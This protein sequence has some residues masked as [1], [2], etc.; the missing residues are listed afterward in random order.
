M[1]GY[2]KQEGGLLGGKKRYFKLDGCSLHYFKDKVRARRSSARSSSARRRAVARARGDSSSFFVLFSRRAAPARRVRRAPP[3]DASRHSAL[4]TPATAVAQ[5]RRRRPRRRRRAR[6]ARASRFSR[7][8]HR[9]PHAAVDDDGGGCAVAAGVG[10]RGRAPTTTAAANDQP[11]RRRRA[12]GK[13]HAGTI[14]CARAKVGRGDKKKKHQLEIDTGT[15]VHTLV[16]ESDQEADAWVGALQAAQ[17]TP[18]TGATKVATVR[19]ARLL[20]R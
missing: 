17:K 20:A 19:A 1:E 7:F 6:R 3:S 8:A 15:K 12:Q 5:R 18:T 14:E 9:T 13:E 2:L 11:L 10:R 4:A 16:A